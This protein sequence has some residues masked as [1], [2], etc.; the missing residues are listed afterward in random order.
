[1]DQFHGIRLEDIPPVINR[2]LTKRDI[3]ETCLVLAKSYNP[4]GDPNGVQQKD[5]IVE[6]DGTFMFFFMILRTKDGVIALD[7]KGNP[8]RRLVFKLHSSEGIS[9]QSR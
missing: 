3:S 4:N 1:M 7:D 6:T 5:I 8:K 9:T 2:S